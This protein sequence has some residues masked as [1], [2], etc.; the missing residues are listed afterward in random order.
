MRAREYTVCLGRSPPLPS[1]RMLIHRL[2]G[3][4]VGPGVNVWIDPSSPGVDSL[5]LGR[6]SGRG[7]GGG[8]ARHLDG[9]PALKGVPA[10]R[11]FV[12]CVWGLM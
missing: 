6:R 2:D 8:V 12:R 11:L 4:N 7:G 9:V 1:G 10:P 3:S 5:M